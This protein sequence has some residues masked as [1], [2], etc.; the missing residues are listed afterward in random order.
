MNILRYILGSISIVGLC[1]GIGIV[2]WCLLIKKGKHKVK[3][4]IDEDFFSVNAGTYLA[5]DLKELGNVPQAF[6]LAFICAGKLYEM[7]N[8][9]PIEI[10]NYIEFVSFP[11]DAAANDPDIEFKG[12]SILVHHFGMGQGRRPTSE[13]GE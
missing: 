6:I 13:K 1:I 3:I 5:Y 11:F 12:A 10:N 4:K 7:G 8:Q 2:V 9:E